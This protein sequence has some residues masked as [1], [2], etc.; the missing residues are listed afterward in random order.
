FD[1]GTSQWSLADSFTPPTNDSGITP[2]TYDVEVIDTDAVYISHL[3]RFSYQRRL[4]VYAGTNVTSLFT[5]SDTTGGIAA[6]AT[7]GDGHIWA[8]PQSTRGGNGYIWE[9][10]PDANTS[11]KHTNIN[12]GYTGM[13]FSDG[14]LT[15]VQSSNHDTFPRDLSLTDGS[16]LASWTSIK[17]G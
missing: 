12:V 6:L 11:T 7:D 15:V 13:D 4:S 2:D 1:S 17:G 5:T 10:D 8:A 14:V 9:Y 16:I 3:W